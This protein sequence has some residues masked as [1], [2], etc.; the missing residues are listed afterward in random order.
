MSTEN[1]GKAFDFKLF[2][3]LMQYARP[4]RFVFWS[5]VIL[6]ILVSVLSVARPWLI[7]FTFDNHVMEGDK[8]MLWVMTQIMIGILVFESLLQFTFIYAANWLGQQIVIDIR[9]KLFKHVLSF[10][11]KYFDKTPIGTL[12]TRV[13]SDMETIAEVFSSGI[14]VIF[15]DLFKLSIV[16]A[17]MFYKNWV[18]TLICLASIPLLLIA[19][20]YFQQGI[21]VAFQ[22][23]RNEVSNLNAFVQEHVSGMN[24]VQIFNR[25]EEEFDKFKAI[26]EKHKKAHI[27][28]IW[29]F[30]VFLPIVEIL[31][32]IS[33]GLMVWY[34]GLSAVKGT[35]VTLGEI[36]E[37]IL[38]IHMLFRPIRQLADRFN[39][40][41]MGMVSSSRV[42]NILDT[43]SH[44]SNEGEKELNEIQ[45]SV[46]FKNVTFAYND[47]DWVLKDI[48]FE[49]KPGETV[50]IVGATGAG[51]TSI[52]NLIT[53][54]YEINKGTISIDGTD[55]KD[56]TLESLRDKIA[57]VLQDVFLYSD[58][59][60]NNITL[61][62][63]I[64]LE[65]VRKAAEAIEVNEFIETLPGQYDYN[66]RERGAMLSAGQRQLIAFLR[67][68]VTNPSILILDEATSSVDTFTEQLIQH[69]IERI[70][71]GRTS[72]V[73]AH[74]LAT[75]QHADKIIVMDK[76]EIVEM[77]SHHELL[78][79]DGF[80]KNLYEKQ[81][82][83]TL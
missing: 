40:L 50:A 56:F 1:T 78:S 68:Y 33:L 80:Y 53:R 67:A 28:S 41:Q 27:K 47:E 38:Y 17:V 65:T 76:G 15:G 48:S 70:T 77:G 25:E 52:I 19:T 2:A 64:P 21:K 69:A 66:V 61:G 44:I 72:I 14:L 79:K 54:L 34:G 43:Q 29:H 36:I 73:I 32:A 5:A 16:I 3:R 13:V 46:E 63:D 20:R 26:N 81:F 35:G 58:S 51:K 62:Q 11:L 4:Y 83:S 45:G 31:S 8:H 24:I 74:R 10:R 82:I 30:A 49:V 39:T 12:I 55:I 23:V 18:L 71:A 75:I 6:T 7:Q 22:R 59:V 42:F 60:L 9:K 37:F 57:V